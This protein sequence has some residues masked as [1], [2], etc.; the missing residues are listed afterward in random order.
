MIKRAEFTMQ[1]KWEIDE[2]TKEIT[3][4]DEYGVKVVY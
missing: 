2:D 1:D 3:V 4:Y